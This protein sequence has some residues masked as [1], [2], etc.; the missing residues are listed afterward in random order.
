MKNKSLLIST[1]FIFLPLIDSLF[2]PQV[3][4]I[5]WHSPKMMYQIGVYLMFIKLLMVIAGIFILLKHERLLYQDT[6]PIRLIRLL[7]FIF[8]GLQVVIMASVCFWYLVA[9]TQAKHFKQQ[10]HINVFTADYGVFAD[11]YHHFTY[12]CYDKQGFYHQEPIASLQ[13][14]GEFSFTVNQDELI[15]HHEDSLGEHSKH[16]SLQG[17]NCS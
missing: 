3:F 15:I 10:Q 16:I 13:W 12:L 8:A 17:F 14:L 2:V 4:G 6:K 1:L 7:S 9:G 5:Q 11:V